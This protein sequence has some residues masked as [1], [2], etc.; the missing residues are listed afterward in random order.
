MVNKP[1]TNDIAQMGKASGRLAF[2]G[3]MLLLM[4]RRGG[5]AALAAE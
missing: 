5:Q 2:E 4:C 3:S 1:L